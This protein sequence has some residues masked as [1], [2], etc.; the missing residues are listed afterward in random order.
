PAMATTHAGSTNIPQCCCGSTDC[1]FLAHNGKLLEGLERDVSKAAQLGQALLIRHETYVADSERER[2]HMLKAI[3]DLER[4]KLQLEEKNA[5]TIKA[6]RELLDELERLNEAV[7]ASDAHVQALTET[8]HSTEE[9]LQRLSALATRTQLL[10][11]QLIDLEREQ[12]QIQH[13]LES[14]TADER[15]AM[16]RWK[17][18]EQTIANLQDQIDRIEKE[19]REEKDRHFEVVARMERRMV[20][21]GELAAAAGRYKAKDGEEKGS[22]TVVSH[23][24]KDILMDNA[25]LQH[26][27]VE[28]REMLLT[29]NEEVERL[30]DQLRVHQP[31]ATPPSVEQQNVET[32]T[33]QKELGPESIYNQELHIHHHY[34]GPAPPK[35]NPKP[36][37]QRRHRNKRF[38][39]T[40]SYFAPFQPDS[41]AAII[42]QT[43]VTVPNSNRW[44][45]AT[46]LA[47]SLPGS[48]LSASHRDSIYDRVFS[49]VPY[50]SSR[51]T[52]PSDSIDL[53]SPMYAPSEMF[54]QSSA[55]HKRKKSHSLRPPT[56]STIRSASTP[57]SITAKSSPATAIISAFSPAN[58]LANDTFALSPSPAPSET[59]AIPEIDEDSLASPSPNPHSLTSPE[60]ERDPDG[61]LSPI[62]IPRPNLRRAASHESLISISGMDIHTLQ[63]RPSQLLL[64]TS[65]RFATPRGAG[66]IQPELTPWTATATAGMS[67]GHLDSSAFNRSLL[68]SSLAS[69]KRTASGGASALS[70]AD[71][72]P[73]TSGITTKIGGWVLGKWGAS[74]TPTTTTTT[75]SSSETTTTTTTSSNPSH[76]NATNKKKKKEKEKEK[77]FKMRPAGVNQ[78]GPIWGFFDTI[79][80]TPTKIV[81]GEAE[82]ERVVVELGEA[83]NE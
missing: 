78:N 44:S 33:L 75:Q 9:E 28:L 61:L 11:R 31:V 22:S 51:P 70:S 77:L 73:R 37:A 30:R 21:N 17:R 19:A 4:D 14:K 67:R 41:Q 65:P 54:A 8:L 80:E 83:L 2:K 25:N 58:S 15:S 47:P 62:Q 50:D 12:S 49:D 53:Q 1:A 72:T 5:Q 60:D 42:S 71:S 39:A 38:S 29:S 34:H 7:A 16:Q 36:K 45:N 13:C 35:S 82:V 10:E 74:P 32:P 40:P 59:A 76:S 64:S 48:P 57:L 69:S 56:L 81:V 20:V 43:S 66:S 79:P 55:Y 27:I 68:Y 46:T 23:F 26:G 3:D 6:N 63:S 52:S 24:V 18:A